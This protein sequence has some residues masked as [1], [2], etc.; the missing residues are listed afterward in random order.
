[1]PDFQ[2]RRRAAAQDLIEWRNALLDKT[3]TIHQD[4]LIVNRTKARGWPGKQRACVLGYLAY[5]GPRLQ[6]L[7]VQNFA[8]SSHIFL[9]VALTKWFGFQE[10]PSPLSDIYICLSNEKA[11]DDAILLFQEAAT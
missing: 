11:L 8:R 3:A 2:L 1:M 5:N 6:V 10:N 9:D 4:Q 7:G